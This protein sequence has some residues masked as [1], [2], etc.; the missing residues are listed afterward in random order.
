MNKFDWNRARAFLATAE[1]GS[2]SAAAR[3]MNMTQ[4]T[5]G[6]QVDALEKELGV[7]LFER[8]GRG[9][10]LTPSGEQLLAHVR[11]MGEAADSFALTASEQSQTIAGK[12]TVAASESVAAYLL[13]EAIATLRSAEPDLHIELVASVGSSDLLRREADIA[14]RHYRPDEPELI[15]KK[16]GEIGARLYATPEYLQRLGNPKHISELSRAEFICFDQA[17]VD[18]FVAMYAGLGAA[19]EP[20]NFPL[21]TRSELVAWQWVKAGLAIGVIEEQIGDNETQVQRV[22]E[23]LAPITAPLWLTSHRELRTNK[24][25][26]RVYDVLDDVLRRQLASGNAK[27]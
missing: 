15:A 27:I 3:A 8:I 17:S 12:I 18:G 9:L 6:R 2:L 7:V 11:A 24:R 10:V 20:A 19:L 16:I 21:L 26:R 13:P 23:D 22:I 4:P 1:Q 14:L 5:L 25:V